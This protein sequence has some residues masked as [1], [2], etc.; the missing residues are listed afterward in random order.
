MPLSRLREDRQGRRVESHTNPKALTCWFS[1]NEKWN[2][3][4]KLVS[5]LPKT[6]SFPTPGTVIPDSARASSRPLP[7]VFGKTAHQ[8]PTESSGEPNSSAHPLFVGRS[9]VCGAFRIVVLQIK[10]PVDITTQ[11]PES[12]QFYWVPNREGLEYNPAAF[13][14]R[15]VS[16]AKLRATLPRNLPWP[17]SEV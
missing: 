8:M 9:T 17:K 11:N 1:A 12:N 14:I 13:S 15:L 3:P 2:D 4:N 5:L 10:K 6:G 7:S 16:L